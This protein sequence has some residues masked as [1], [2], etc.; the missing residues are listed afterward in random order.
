MFLFHAR[1]LAQAAERP[2]HLG[3]TPDEVERSHTVSQLRVSAMNWPVQEFGSRT[4]VAMLT[5]GWPH[6]TGTEVSQNM[7]IH[8]LNCGHNRICRSV[9]E[10][11]AFL[12]TAGTSQFLL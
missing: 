11:R 8:W 7:P 5:D 3:P 12:L 1:W 9:C 6:S 2:G 4:L 10:R